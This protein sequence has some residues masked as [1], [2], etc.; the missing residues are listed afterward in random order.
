MASEAGHFVFADVVEA[1]CRKMIRRHPHVFGQDREGSAAAAKSRWEDMK[2]AERQPSQGPT[3]GD[4]PRALPGLS[5]ALKLQA[6]AARVGF[7][8]P[9]TDAVI[10][11]IVEEAKELRDAPGDKRA[12]EFGDLLF[13][14]VNLGRHLGI[15][16]EAALRSAN[17]KFERRF[18]RIETAL[19]Q[20]GKVPAQST[21][22]EMDELWDEAK[23]NEA[24]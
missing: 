20:R 11:K 17:A 7:D 23:R 21:L 19:A 3:L 4:V 2:A 9:A 5:R 14:I 15:D 10:E 16:A 22:A 13:A 24:R 6:K 1:I 12:E 8:W 18:A